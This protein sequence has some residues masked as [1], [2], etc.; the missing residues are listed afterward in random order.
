M[1]AVIVA[2]LLVPVHA[3]AAEE[4]AAMEPAS[5]TGKE[6]LGSKASDEQRVNDCKVP[7]EL[8]GTSSRPVDCTHIKTSP[9]RSDEEAGPGTDQ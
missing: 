3:G 5:R 9:A 4:E 6:R 7:P 2:A 1:A 8:R